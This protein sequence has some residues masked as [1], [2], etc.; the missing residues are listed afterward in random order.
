MT[1][2]YFLLIDELSITQSYPT[3]ETKELSGLNSLVFTMMKHIAT[4]KEKKDS[5]ISPKGE[6]KTFFTFQLCV[7]EATL[8]SYHHPKLSTIYACMAAASFSD[9]TSSTSLPS[10]MPQ[11]LIS[12]LC[13]ELY[14]AIVVFCSTPTTSTTSHY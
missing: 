12:D 13:N 14:I 5:D 10:S 1:T 7:C 2:K 4:N 8:T 11:T 3:T 6:N 9:P